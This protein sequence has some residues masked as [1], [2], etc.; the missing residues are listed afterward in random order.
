MRHP[1]K[2]LIPKKVLCD[3]DGVLGDVS[4]PIIAHI[5]EK[6]GQN[7][8]REDW[9]CWDWPVNQLVLLA[10]LDPCTAATW[11]FSSEHFWQAPP[12]IEAQQVLEFWANK[13]SHISVATSRPPLEREVTLAWLAKYYPFISP[14]DIHIREKHIKGY[15]HKG[16]NAELI[17]PDRYFEDDPDTLLQLI[18]RWSKRM[19]KIIRFINQPWNQDCPKLEQFRTTWNSQR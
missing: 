11:L 19:Q 9:T 2:G 7:F 8:V 15:E 13:G 17:L 12:I 14:R 1:E 4:I 16:Q 18:A 5:N 3:I 10:H 6:Y